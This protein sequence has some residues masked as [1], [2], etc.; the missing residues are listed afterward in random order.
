V[1]RSAALVVFALLLGCSPQ[2]PGPQ[3]LTAEAKAYV[4]NLALS[5]VEMK[6]TESYAKQVLTEI[7]GNIT[8]NGNRTVARV[9]VNCI[10]YDA[11]GQMVRREREAIVRTSLAPGQTHR[12]R[13][14]FDD[15]PESWNNRMPQLVIA[16]VLFG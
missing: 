9:E 2:P 3:P 1:D 5:G 16:Q 13:L 6:A 10:F 11:Y 15:I 14:A 4:R 12:F 7:E 8:N